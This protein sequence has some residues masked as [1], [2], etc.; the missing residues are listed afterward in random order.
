MAPVA[1]ET[2]V[3]LDFCAKI[4]AECGPIIEHLGERCPFAEARI[5]GLGS[6]SGKTKRK[7]LRFYDKAGKLLLTGEVKMP[8]GPPAFDTELI[9]DAQRKADHANVQYFFTWDV[10]R[11]VLWDRYQQQKSLLDRRVN[12][13]NTRL[14]LAS[15]QEVARPEILGAIAKKFLPGLI[16]DVSDILTGARRDWAL[17]PDEI[18]LRSL[19]SH[20]DWP[21]TLLRAYLFTNANASREFDQNLQQWMTAQGRQF[22]RNQPE[23]WR[24]AVDNAARTLAY[25]WTNRFI[26]YKA[27]R[28]RFPELPQLE[29]GPAV[30]APERAIHRIRELFARATEVSGDYETLLFPREKDWANDLIFAPEGA[31]DAWRGFLKGIE[32]VDFSQVPSDVV[33]LIFQKLVSP[34]ER[35]RLGQHF[36]G[37]DPVDLINAFCIRRPT[38]NVLDPACGSG[39]F[40]V[41][42]YYRKRTMNDARPHAELLKELYGCDIALYPAHL[43]TLNLAARE[44][45]DEA[46]YPRVARRDFLTLTNG[47]NFCEF[48]GSL[49]NGPS[50]I[51]LPSLDAVVGNPPY[52]RQEKIGDKKAE[53]ERRIAVDLQGARLSGRADLHCYFWP[54]AAVFLREGG[55]FGFLT[56]AQWLDVQYGFALQRWILKNFRIVAIMESSAERWF[57]DARVKTC[58][59]VLQRCSD[60]HT[61][62]QNVVRFV[63]FEA[64]LEALIGVSA[65]GGV[66]SD[67]ERSERARQAA[68]GRL[69]D[70]IEH[71]EE[72]CHDP[73]WRIL[74][75]RQGDLWDQGVRA[76]ALLAKAEP[77][78]S[79]DGDEEAD[80]GGEGET[81]AD[82]GDLDATDY[83]AGK[84]GRYLRAPDLYFELMQ[85]Y[86]ARFVCLGEIAQIRFGL[87][88]G[89][90]AFFMPRD[91]TAETLGVL[92]DAA[93][94]RTKFGVP[95]RAVEDGTVKIIKDGAG[96]LFP[97]EAEYLQPE[98]H[99]L[100]N[101]RRPELR[102]RDTN[103]VVLLVG[104]PLAA[105]RGTHV[106]KYIKH[107][108]SAVYTS[109][110]SKPVAV[111]QRT[112]VAGRHPWYDLTKLVQP[113]IAFWPMAQ[114]YRHIAP[115]NPESL[116]CNHNLF[117]IAAENLSKRERAVLIAVLNSTMVGLFKTFYGRFAGAEGNLKTE[118]I[119]VNLMEIPDPRKASDAVAGRLIAALRRM[120][121]RDI[122]RFVEEAFMQC[123]SYERANE[124]ASRPIELPQELLQ[125]D[126]RDL[127][128]AVLE[129]LGVTDATER[130]RL[131]ERLY[132]ETAA[133]LR[134]I[135]V[136]EIQKQEDRASGGERRL[137]AADQAADVWDALQT[138]DRV[139]LADWLRANAPSPIAEVDL[140]E[141]R[142]IYLASG[143]M[144]DHET[145]YFGKNRERH[146]VLPS[147][148]AA[149]LAARVAELGLS[150]KQPLPVEDEAARELLDRINARHQNALA[151]ARPLVESRTGAADEQGAIMKI[152]ARW[153]VI[154]KPRP[155][156][157]ASNAGA[158]AHP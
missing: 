74:L 30:R 140:P 24:D 157:L 138:A 100:M 89:C 126:R 10:N 84:W 145:V 110:K 64:P 150:G 1:N 53:Y 5:E 27:L 8:G 116:I 106:L 141:E 75:V 114:Q 21:V 67:A 31:V 104:K 135:R 17:P 153:L 151:E 142:P 55:Y 90:D 41:R 35:H 52:V 71:Q 61:R 40:L 12:V 94:F 46:N 96:S 62:E 146:L 101:V 123:H 154:G 155:V 143:S 109:S 42:A 120:A 51:A 49:R 7:D 139:P 26:F 144:F 18:F 11:F 43:A 48:P 56:S 105:L 2:I 29:L 38:D 77:E 88:S 121:K 15:A 131:R 68:V 4:A 92:T 63:R 103:R 136:I 50:S 99:N 73:R 122:G 137:T 58:I 102:A 54:H 60:P 91:V 97:I 119:D 87:K 86:P 23:N 19:E 16:A 147:R 28:A 127:D 37:A 13:W 134:A 93:K 83:A 117:D 22:L 132:E 108:D 45:N 129:L 149:E 80:D 78:A 125:D 113:G 124:L 98:V 70:T 76:G 65:S 39:S 69:R 79:E 81:A 152:I 57:P 112:S 33:G 6:T 25:V 3:E 130:A 95:R 85:K 118:V 128:D 32:A 156:E 36:T 9:E 59:T 107:G 72:D 44:I 47:D 158:A 14:N 20:L 82:Q 66:G 115:S 133:H 34:D 148:A 111:P